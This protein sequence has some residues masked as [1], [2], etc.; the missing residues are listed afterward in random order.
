VQV[1]VRGSE[2]VGVALAAVARARSTLRKLY[3]QD[4]V[5][6]VAWKTAPPVAG[7]AMGTAAAAAGAA[8][9]KGSSSSGS[10][11]GTS[12]PAQASLQQQQQQLPRSM[13]LL[14]PLPQP[15]VPAHVSTPGTSTNPEY[16]QQEQQPGHQQ[17][18]KQAGLAAATPADAPVLPRKLYKLVVMS[19]DV[20][21][22][23]SGW[24]HLSPHRRGSEQQ[25]RWL[26]QARGQMQ[27]RQRQRQQQTRAKRL[28]W[29]RLRPRSSPQQ[30]PS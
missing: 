7:A 2:G 12:S 11:S 30:P 13:L 10:S 26:V 3:Q 14:P 18:G 22:P 9:I 29:F 25:Q 17:S 21:D 5:V 28:R 19:C 1:L 24:K 23:M 16:R 27:Q 15:M 20:D 6:Y 4:C 8:P